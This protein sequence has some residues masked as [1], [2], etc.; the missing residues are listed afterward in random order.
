MFENAGKA[1][2]DFFTGSVTAI[3]RRTRR[4]FT[5]GWRANQGRSR[6]LQ[7]MDPLVQ[8]GNSVSQSFALMDLAGVTASDSL[9]LADQKVKN[10]ITGYQA[11][12]VQGNL[13]SGAVNAVTF[14][15]EQ[16]QS[17]VQALTQAYSTW[18][19]TITGGV[20]T[21]TTFATQAIGLYGAL[22]SGA[23]TLSSR[24]GEVAVSMQG[25]AA[26]SG[27]T[28]VSMTGLN[29][30]SLNAQ[31]TFIQSASAAQSQYNSL[32]TLASAAGLGSR[33]TGMLTGA[34][35]DYMAILMRR[36]GTTRRCSSPW[37][38]CTRRSTRTSPVSGSWRR[39]TQHQEP[40]AGPAE[41]K[42]TA[43]TRPPGNLAQDVQNLAQA[44]GQNLNQA[45]A[46]AILQ[47]NGGQQ[48]F[49]N[50]ATAVLGGKANSQKRPLPR[51]R[52]RKSCSR[53]PTTRRPPRPRLS[54]G[55]R[56]WECPSRRPS[57]CG[58]RS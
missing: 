42:T 44:I 5:G 51:R 50:Y 37:S 17:K 47:A 52:S 6:T 8:S 38:A 21:F 48:A 15:S 13:L 56:K 30:A 46:A 25:L 1:I 16:Q 10:L 54:P 49:D 43:F 7:D 32:L 9:A 3:R 18:F 34:M 53:V 19:S 11:M 24:N 20:S 57:N 12:S 45:M 22:S 2:G 39:P 41:E 14:A 31:Q 26:Q 4:T 29:A 27:D 33:G 40:D 55:P 23:A 28:T 35:K 36:R 58:T